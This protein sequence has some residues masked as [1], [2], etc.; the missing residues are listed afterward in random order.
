[1]RFPSGPPGQR[2]LPAGGPTV[3]VPP[4]RPGVEGDR[5]LGGELPF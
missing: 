1:M 4:G 5:T 3:L 2:S